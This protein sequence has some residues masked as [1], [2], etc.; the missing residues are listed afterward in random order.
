VTQKKV[1]KVAELF[2]LYYGKEK[3]WYSKGAVVR[4]PNGLAFLSGMSGVDPETGHIVVGDVRS[5]TTIAWKKIKKHLE[6]M[7][8][9]LENIVKIVYYVPDR[10]DMEAM[11]KANHD[12]WKEN[13]PELLETA[14]P[15]TVVVSGLYHTGYQVEIDVIAAVPPQ[16]K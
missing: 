16:E 1:P 14:P 2:P 3:K 7:G 6:D 4:P 9:S 10:R 8:S 5:H 13:C 12:F 15:N 11:M